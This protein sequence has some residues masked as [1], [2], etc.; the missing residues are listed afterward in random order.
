ML[1]RKAKPRRP[2]AGERS[3]LPSAADKSTKQAEGAQRPVRKVQARRAQPE[4]GRP[5][6]QNQLAKRPEGGW[7]GGPFKRDVGGIGPACFKR[8][9]ASMTSAGGLSVFFAAG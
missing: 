7:F 4:Q 6:I 8:K 5:P 9:P 1:I 2:K 3:T